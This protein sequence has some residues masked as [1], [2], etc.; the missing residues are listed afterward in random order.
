L[1]K[2]NKIDKP[3]TNLTQMRRKKTHISKIGSEKGEIITNTKEIQGIVR[4][5]TLKT[6]IQINGK[7]LMKWTIF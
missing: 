5:Y 1:K 4:N 6:Y 2:I 7:I 3:L